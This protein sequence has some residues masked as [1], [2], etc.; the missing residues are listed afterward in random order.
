MDSDSVAPSVVSEQP[1]VL[2]VEPEEDESDELNSD[3]DEDPV[4]RIPGETLLPSLRLEG[5]IKAD[6]VM[7]SLA[8]S[9]EGLF[10][11]AVATEEFIKRLAQ[12]GYRQ[13][14]VERRACVN[15][16]DMAATT[17]QYQ[18]FMFLQE[19]IPSPV[20][21]SEALQLRE[22]KEKE[23]LEDDPAL[24]APTTTTYSSTAGYTPS[25]SKPKVKS[26]VPNGKDRQNRRGSSSR[27]ESRAHSQVRWDYED[28]PASN[29]HG[30][31]AAMT[32]TRGGRE[33]GWT[34]WPN[35]QNFIPVNPLPAAP[36][37]N[38]FN[39]L[40]HQPP[41][42]PSINGHTPLPPRPRDGETSPAQQHPNYW[43]RSASPWSK[44]VFETPA[45]RP[46]D[47]ISAGPIPTP[48]QNEPD[49]PLAQSST[50]A[51]PAQP[52]TDTA[53]AVPIRVPTGPAGPSTL[54][55]QNPGRTIYSQK[56][57]PH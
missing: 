45:L 21:L 18:E 40:A 37:H 2:E 38:G 54:V 8:L 41:S 44:G 52:L 3:M 24:V 17:Q 22:L 47:P 50:S 20:S 57:N 33:S 39:S 32:S 55:S 30:Q 29:G 14:G 12:G 4:E 35:G 42:M 23:I 34:R 7:G 25:T 19:T 49:P 11:L 51:P 56:K 46:S 26:R 36:L 31:G 13:A 48:P 43:Q 10:I 5:I 1:P 28:T 9:K 53:P 15:Y 6:G 27:S 16:R